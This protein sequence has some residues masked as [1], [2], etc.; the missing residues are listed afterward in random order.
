VELAIKGGEENESNFGRIIGMKMGTPF[1]SL[2][3]FAP[4]V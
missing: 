4:S 2:L 1:F 3:V